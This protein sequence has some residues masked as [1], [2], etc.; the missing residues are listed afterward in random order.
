MRPRL[1][2]R[3]AALPS[4]LLALSCSTSLPGPPPPSGAP[5]PALA[6]APK[7]A[8]ADVLISGV[9][10]VRQK[11]DFCGEACVE[12]ALQ[13]LG[14]A[15]SQDE[16]FNRSGVDPSLGRGVT[17]PELK[18]TLERV[19]FDPGPVWSYV[20]ATSG[21]AGLAKEFDALYSDLRAGIPSI[22]C[23]HYDGSPN[24]T[25]H[26]RLVL[27][28]DGARDEVIYNEPAED[29]GAYRR[30]PRAQFLGLW[31]L[32]YAEDRWTVIRLRLD[33]KRLDQASAAPAA[34]SGPSPSAYAQH[35]LELR[36]RI[37][38]GFTVR[39]EPPFVVIGDGGARAVE[40]HAVNTVRW[41]TSRLKQ[42]YFTRDPKQILDIWL[43]KDAKSYTDNTLALFNETP[44]TPYGYYSPGHRSLFMN[45]ATGGGTL[46][47]EI[48][49]PFIEAN[50][51]GCPPW[52]NEGLGS[53]Y[54]QS[55][56]E[57]G[58]IHG[59]TNWRL[60]GLKKA[61]RAE[62]VPSFK[63]LMSANEHAFYGEDPG[64][65]YAQARYLLYYL[66][67]KGL[68]VRFYREFYEHRESDPSGEKTLSRVLGE[69]DMGA[70]KQRWES[71][72]MGL[73]F[74]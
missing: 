61:I 39:I 57:A 11:P 32:K 19:G 66:Q 58:H 3:S 35:V 29:A 14:R 21:A 16:V 71:F 4:L 26:F 50:F 41:A 20:E 7:P 6:L 69:N 40:R 10:H 18:T 5:D 30:M 48:V 9:P 64:T 22:V 17:T 25:E 36:R 15:V 45:I 62:R 68:L 47:H 43:F 52:F 24:T 70:F 46:V 60:A 72:V 44:S 1:S 54:E 12:M 38:R 73:S 56:E 74:P 37:G 23:M 67:Q 13:K 2:G 34:P 65:N 27:G 59:Y 53:L 51:P 49:H 42:D 63:Q 8:Y 31:P 33:P 28:Y 55:G